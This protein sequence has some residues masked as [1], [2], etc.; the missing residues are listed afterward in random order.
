M[1]SKVFEVTCWLLSTE[2]SDFARL[3]QTLDDLGFVVCIVDASY[4]ELTRVAVLLPVVVPVTP[5]VCPETKHIHLQMQ[6]GK[7]RGY[8]EETIR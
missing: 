2:Y 4:A 6:D 1:K 8:I 5:T 7:E 3:G